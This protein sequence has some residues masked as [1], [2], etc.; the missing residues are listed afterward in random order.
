MLNND[1]KIIIATGIFP[2]DIGGPATYSVFLANKILQNK[3]DVV[4][5]TYADDILPLDSNFDFRVVRIS[6][7]DFILR[8]YFNYFKAVFNLADKNSVVYAQDPVSS[9]LPAFFASFLRGSK[10]ILKIVGDY[11]WEQGRSRFGVSDSIEVFQKKRYGFFV[12]V[13]KF[14]ERF[15]AKRAN[16]IIV[17]SEF[18]KK[19]VL[20]FGVPEER[21]FVIYNSFNEDTKINCKKNK[22][23]K[24]DVLV[25]VGRLVP[26][27]GFSEL[28]KIMPELLKENKNFVLNIIGDGPE[29]ENLEKLI[30]KLKLKT[31][32]FLMGKMSKDELFCEIK[33]SKI[34]LLNTSYEGFSHQILEV[35]KLGVPV[36]TTNVGGNPEVIVNEKN[37]ILVTLGD[38]ETFKSEILR[39]NSSSSL[40]RELV[41]NAK[42][43]LKMF[44]EENMVKDT[45]EIL[46][47]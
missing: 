32:V 8:R 37:G 38:M 3:G 27:K 46:Y 16:K 30:D 31:K 34:F 41:K 18:L 13:F 29:R 39:V 44:D 2:P 26:W 14:I 47:K 35:M 9:G 17:P 43:F 45:L 22:K 4:V 23:A 28:I 36:I 10:F 40:R 24:K 21:I 11:A 7:E 20:M 42:N 12:S 6:R 5:V 19:I 1:K 33:K 25:S 15:V